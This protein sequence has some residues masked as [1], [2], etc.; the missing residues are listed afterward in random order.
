MRHPRGGRT[1][2]RHLE[3]TNPRAAADRPAWNSHHWLV[4][5]RGFVAAF[6]LPHRLRRPHGRHHLVQ[7]LARI[8]VVYRDEFV[9]CVCIAACT[10]ASVCQVDTRLRVA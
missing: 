6:T 3:T 10:Q 2:P 9:H 1:D 8:L 5:L 7:L 4:R